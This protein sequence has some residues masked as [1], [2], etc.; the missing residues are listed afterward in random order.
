MSVIDSLTGLYSL[1]DDEDFLSKQKNDIYDHVSNARLNYVVCK[2]LVS[3]NR[4]QF[5]SCHWPK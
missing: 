3:S 2:R 4:L 1:A 5:D